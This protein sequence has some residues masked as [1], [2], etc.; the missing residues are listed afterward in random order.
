MQRSTIIIDWEDNTDP[1]TIE[2]KLLE[3]V[4]QLYL[5]GLPYGVNKVFKV[6]MK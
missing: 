1:E 5:T 6:E 3:W 4:E 2:K